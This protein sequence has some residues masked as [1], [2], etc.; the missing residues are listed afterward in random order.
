M[1]KILDYYGKEI[2]EE[3]AKQTS[4]AEY[5][6][7]NAEE[8]LIDLIIEKETLKFHWQTSGEVEK[9]KKD[10]YHK[11]V[12]LDNYFEWNDHV[13]MSMMGYFVCIDKIK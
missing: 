10:I 8:A 4:L 12:K 5:K 3:Q 6:Y 1:K 9:I 7:D 13:F 2:T 11:G